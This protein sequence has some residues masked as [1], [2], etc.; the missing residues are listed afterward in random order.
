MVCIILNI[1]TMAMVF[2]AAPDAYLNSL[3]NINLFF[4]SVFISEAFLKI[5]AYGPRGY[6]YSNWNR[7]DFFVV[8]T[9]I[10]DIALDYSG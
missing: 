9:S 3:K 5:F 10:L 6:F 2:E 1:A 8:C 7:F 4:T